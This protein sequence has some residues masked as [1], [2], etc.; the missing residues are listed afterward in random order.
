MG[1]LR[2]G[3][4]SKLQTWGQGVVSTDSLSHCG[5]WHNVSVKKEKRKKRKTYPIVVHCALC[6]LEFVKSI[7][8]TSK[9]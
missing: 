4:R 7:V 2:G 5:S 9:C 6:A 8:D 1:R 3:V